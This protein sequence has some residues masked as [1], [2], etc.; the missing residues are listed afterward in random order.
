MEIWAGDRRTWRSIMHGRELMSQGLIK[1]IGN[2]E[3]TKV[4]LENWVVDTV[5]RLPNY[6]QDDFVD[7]TLS[8][9]DYRA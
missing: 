3:Y 6:H 8:V 7:L 1:K 4:W 9:N 2:M 5:P